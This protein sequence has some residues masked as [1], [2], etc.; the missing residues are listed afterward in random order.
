MQ[1]FKLNNGCEIP[2]LGLG[3]FGNEKKNFTKAL[4]SA[5][6]IGYRLFDTSP[7]YKNEDGLNETFMFFSK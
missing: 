3:T 5:S 2:A 6:Q 7:A 4:K 1:Y